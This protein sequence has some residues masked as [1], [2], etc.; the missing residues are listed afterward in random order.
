M[1]TTEDE[2]PKSP[3]ERALGLFAEVRAGEGLTAVLLT[4][5][6]FL[7]LTCYYLLKTAREPLILASGAEVKSYASAGQA[8]LLIFFTI[9]Y[10]KVAERVNRMRL[11]TIVT[12]FFGSNIVLFFMAG[13]AGL[14][15]GIPF[16]LWVGIFNYMIIAQFWSFAADLYTDEQGKRLFAIHGIGSTLGAVCGSL[17]AK[18]L[19]KP[20]GVFG[21]MIGAA[22]L[23]AL[24]LGVTFI[25]N[26]RESDRDKK[27]AK[28]RGEEKMGKEGGFSMLIRDKYLL[29][30][31]ALTLIINWVNSSGEYILDRTLVKAA[32]VVPAGA[33]AHKW[34]E[35]FI[36]SYK[37]DYFLW[38][39]IVGVVLQLFVVSRVIKYLGLRVALFIMPIVS[40]TGYSVMSFL[41]VLPFIFGVKIVENSLD[42]SLENTSRQA[43][44]LVTTRDAKYKAKA[45]IDTF[46]V[47]AGDVC[48]AGVV[49]VGTMLSFDTR[50]FILINAGMAL[51]W[52]GVVFLLTR[53]YAKR[54]QEQPAA[55][56]P[57]R[58][59]A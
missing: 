32:S 36:G 21:L 37:A 3:L 17:I 15:V 25:V 28:P 23:L 13:L 40:L 19:I 26:Q 44:W 42:Y 30:L 47:R 45:V 55:A 39:N 43:L 29:L 53:E 24:S 14:N 8:V 20:V 5:D 34:S 35:Q 9:A 57:V 4:L 48:S 6:V 16:F 54:S 10:G 49:W 27:S 46:I 52:T 50:H 56:L 18:E 11:I 2:G 58:E 31:G 38:V 7:L 51:V 59:A 1:A 41:P 33:D 12:I 22:I